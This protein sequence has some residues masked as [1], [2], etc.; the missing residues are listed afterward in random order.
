MLFKKG[1]KNKKI[2]SGFYIIDLD[3]YENIK[4]E[5]I[6]NSR[7]ISC[8]TKVRE[9][10][11]ICNV[12]FTFKNDYTHKNYGLMS[13]EILEKNGKI[14]INKKAIKNGDHKM[15]NNRDMINDCFILCSLNKNNQMLKIDE[16]G[17]IIFFL[18]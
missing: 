14:I 10:I 11:F 2:T 12:D 18:I 15:I 4:I 13:F 8:I 5:Y 16:E 7:N 1:K 9:N 17:N 3:D 6:N